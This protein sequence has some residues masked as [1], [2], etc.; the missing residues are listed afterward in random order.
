MNNF[1]HIF[2]NRYH[3]DLVLGDADGV[4]VIPRHQV[5]SVLA[6]AQA[7]VDAESARMAEIARGDLMP[8]FLNACLR[9]AG[10]IASQQDWQA[11]G[12]SE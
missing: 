12:A 8:D 2:D 11:L 7:K 3:Y 1:H 9:H 10:L 5:A 4:T 6:Q